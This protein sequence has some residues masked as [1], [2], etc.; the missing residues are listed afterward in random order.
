MFLNLFSD[1]GIENIS[2]YK[3]LTHRDTTNVQAFFGL[4]F[5]AAEVSTTKNS[6][7][8]DAF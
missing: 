1:A 5:S 7:F 3:L 6:A 2:I 8:F 4:L